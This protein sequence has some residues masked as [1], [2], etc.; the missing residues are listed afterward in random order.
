MNFETRRKIRKVPGTLCVA[1]I[2]IV[3]I[4]MLAKLF[5]VLPTHPETTCTTGDSVDWGWQL[6]VITA[7]LVYAF[8]YVFIK[9]SR[10]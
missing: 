9:V 1:A 5:G 3:V 8:L 4:G 7:A 2:G 6:V 10:R